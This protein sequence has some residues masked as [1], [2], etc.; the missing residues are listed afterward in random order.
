MVAS[1][2]SCCFS[3]DI[4]YAGIYSPIVAFRITSKI[5]REPAIPDDPD[6][7]Y[8]QLYSDQFTSFEKKLGSSFYMDTFT[9]V[10]C[11]PVIYPY[12]SRKF[13]ISRPFDVEILS[14]EL[15]IY[16]STYIVTQLYGEEPI[17][18]GS[19]RLTGEDSYD[20]IGEFTIT[21]PISL[22]DLSDFLNSKLRFF[23]DS[24][25]SDVSDFHSSFTSNY[26]YRSKECNC[27]FK[28]KSK[29]ILHNGCS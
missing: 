11:P 28:F 3:S 16:L 13:S 17:S 29:F 25:L 12:F 24:I 1:I 23:Y 20:L 4:R 2:C 9:E 6:Y 26:L 14:F 10:S 8:S 18:Q 27:L 7:N 5:F 15:K 22:S 21:P 19:Y